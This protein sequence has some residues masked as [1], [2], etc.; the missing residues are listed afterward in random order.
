MFCL[1]INFP[2]FMYNRPQQMYITI[3]VGLLLGGLL[4]ICILVMADGSR[5]QELE[6][7]KKENAHV[8]SK[9]WNYIRKY[10]YIHFLFRG[11]V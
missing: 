1:S 2:D 8:P 9:G 11:K 10:K 5:E 3:Q 6:V 7:K 4:G